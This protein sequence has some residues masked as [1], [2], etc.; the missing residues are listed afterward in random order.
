MEILDATIHAGS[1]MIRALIIYRP[2]YSDKHR[3]TVPTFLSE[4]GGLMES[5][6]VSSGHLLIL[7]DFNIHM[8]NSECPEAQQFVDLISSLGLAQHVVGSTHKNGHT[9]DLVLTR[10]TDAWLG[11]FAIDH[12]MPSDHSAVHFTS[13]TYRPPPLKITKDQRVLKDIDPATLKASVMSSVKRMESTVN[14]NCLASAYKLELTSVMNEHAPIKK[15]TSIDKP[16]A[17][18]F[19]S[20]LLSERRA[21]RKLE[22]QWLSSKLEIHRQMFTAARAKYN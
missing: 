20:D 13:M 17:E 18:W 9:L 1:T 19:S 4:F 5:M 12:T 16:R 6:I 21:L 14:A 3:I 2:P 10:A 8:D 22:R 7:G 15:K 11:N